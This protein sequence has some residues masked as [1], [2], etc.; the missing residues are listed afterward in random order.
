MKIRTDF[1][2]NSSSVS[3]IIT[4]HKNIVE[5]FEK[6]YGSS[7]SDKYKR[8][9]KVLKQ[10]M[11]EKGTRTYLEDEEIYVQ[12]I[13]FNTDDGVTIDDSLLKEEKREL[14]FMSIDDEELWNYIRGEYILSGTLG[15]ISGFGVT[16]IEQ[17]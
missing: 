11:L 17:Y 3:F 10:D 5:V 1:V 2:T 9:V 4:M 13:K 6:W 15:K 12:K 16:Q 8:I 14:D 7:A